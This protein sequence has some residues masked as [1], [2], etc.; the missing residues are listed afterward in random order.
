MKLFFKNSIQKLS[1]I[2]MEWFLHEYTEISSK[3]L[4]KYYTLVN[5]HIISLHTMRENKIPNDIRM[6]PAWVLYISLLNHTNSNNIKKYI[7]PML[8]HI[9]RVVS[10]STPS[11]IPF[12]ALG[13]VV[14]KLNKPTAT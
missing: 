12:F 7:L 9:E 2:N 4:Q 3:I 1:N 8:K 11:S 10:Y 13:I 14:I 5:E 6:T